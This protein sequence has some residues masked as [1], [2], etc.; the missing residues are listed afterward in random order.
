MRFVLGLSLLLVSCVSIDR[1]PVLAGGLKEVYIENVTDL[2]EMGNTSEA[3]Q[4]LDFLRRQNSVDQENL[5]QLE[6]RSVTKLVNQLNEHLANE[7]YESAYP[8]YLTLETISQSDRVPNWSREAILKAYAEQSISEG[9]LVSAFVTFLQLYQND[10][11]NVAVMNELLALAYQ[12]KNPFVIRTLKESFENQGEEIPQIYEPVIPNVSTSE[13]LGG[14]ATVWVDK[15]IKIEKGVGYPDQVMGSAFFIDPEG[16]LL[17][18]HHIIESEVDP[19]YEGFSR[20]YVRLPGKPEEK[21]PA[22]VHGW[23]RIFDIA[24]LKVE[25]EPEF[26]FSLASDISVDPGQSVLAIGSP[27]DPFLENTITAG[28]VSAPSRRKLLQMGD[29]IQVDVPVNPGNSGGPLINEQNA[30]VGMVFAGF[31]SYEGLNFAIPMGWIIKAIPYLYGG[32]ERT[33]TWLGMALIESEKGLETIYTV[34]G[35]SADRGGIRAGDIVKSINGRVFGS[36][37]DVQEFFINTPPATL[38][39]V[40]WQRGET[41]M[42]GLFSLRDRPFSPIET[43]LDRDS[44]QNILVPLFGMQLKEVSNFLWET[45]YVVERV[46]PGS[47]ADNTGISESDALNVQAW[48]VDTETRSVNLQIFVKKRQAGFLES[49]I[50]LVAYMESDIYV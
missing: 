32:G 46:I 13:M 18:S 42:S 9:R 21:I 29:V 5:D 40:K 11:T 2:I 14:M 39:R 50:R 17:T 37:Q 25:V 47:I 31:Q 28:I 26:V 49:V 48:D 33:Y 20:L 3:L 1:S 41:E 45:N 7:Q 43:A 24:L 38:V 27:L 12:M 34:P 10:R 4:D 30:V 6:R 8:L 16:Y 36:I 15:G 35:E 19:E 23:D 22:K 44:I